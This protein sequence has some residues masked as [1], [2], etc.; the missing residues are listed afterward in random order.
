VIAFSDVSSDSGYTLSL[1][2]ECLKRKIE[3]KSD[4][5]VESGHFAEE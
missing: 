3:R 5:W 2:G 4:A 1:F